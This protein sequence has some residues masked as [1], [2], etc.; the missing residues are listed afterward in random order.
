MIST[1]PTCKYGKVIGEIRSLHTLRGQSRSL[2][3][4]S[5]SCLCTYYMHHPKQHVTL[6]VAVNTAASVL[7]CHITTR[8]DITSPF[9]VHLFNSRTTVMPPLRY[10]L[11]MKRI[12]AHNRTPTVQWL[13]SGLDDREIVIRLQ[14]GK[15]NFL[16]SIAFGAIKPIQC[17][18]WT[19][20][21]RV[22]RPGRESNHSPTASV[23]VNNR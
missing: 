14:T 19:I 16:F 20:A 13:G 1:W 21:H 3:S 10:L 15:E 12:I 2:M 18:Q 4:L 11:Q 22:R 5:S 17:L 7:L 6:P 8:S 9:S 23:D